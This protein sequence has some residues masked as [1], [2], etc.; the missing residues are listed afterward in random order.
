MSKKEDFKKYFE[1][2]LDS[3]ILI[4]F[5]K[6]IREAADF[7][8]VAKDK[9]KISIF[10]SIELIIGA[11]NQKE[12]SSIEEFLSKFNIADLNAEIGRLAYGLIRE[13]NKTIGLKIIDAMIAATAVNN[14]LILVT[15]NT[16]HFDKIRELRIKVP[17]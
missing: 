5:S 7:L 10:S 11:R 17:Y 15:R 8:N 3:D 6:G 9:S 14:E 1:Y 16:R 13:Y 2:L 4:D 12:L